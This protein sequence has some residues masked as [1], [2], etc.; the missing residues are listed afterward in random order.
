LH[1][2]ECLLRYLFLT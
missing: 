2:Y 1:I